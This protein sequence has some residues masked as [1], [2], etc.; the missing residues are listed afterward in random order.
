MTNRQYTQA[1]DL[2]RAKIAKAPLGKDVK[3]LKR[4]DISS[5]DA[6]LSKRNLAAL[7]RHFDDRMPWQR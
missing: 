7:T 6:L 5:G 4:F 2:V 3:S 1:D